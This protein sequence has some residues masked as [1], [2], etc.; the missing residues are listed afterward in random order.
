MNYFSAT[1]C[2]FCQKFF[3]IECIKRFDKGI[4]IEDSSRW[5]YKKHISRACDIDYDKINM[6]QLLNE[7]NDVI[8]CK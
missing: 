6:L 2:Y 5:K 8:H 1:K 7:G 3:H 4:I